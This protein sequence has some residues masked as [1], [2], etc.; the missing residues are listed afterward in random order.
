MAQ[1][2]PYM[3]IVTFAYAFKGVS[4]T[5][6]I[7]LAGFA[8]I[9]VE[10]LELNNHIPWPVEPVLQMIYMFFFDWI[11]EIPDRKILRTLQGTSIG[12]SM[13]II[14]SE[15]IYL[16]TIDKILLCKQLLI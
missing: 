5:L 1:P 16:A 7:S 8:I 6:A 12:V 11:N 15:I 3:L 2:L 4:Y 9:K 14:I 13:I 10:L